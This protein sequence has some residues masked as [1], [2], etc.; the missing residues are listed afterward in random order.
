VFLY[1]QKGS[2]AFT[3]ISGVALSVVTGVVCAR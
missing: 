1:S 3:V 2:L